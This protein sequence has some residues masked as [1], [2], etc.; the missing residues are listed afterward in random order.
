MQGLLSKLVRPLFILESKW[1]R[2]A[3]L[4]FTTQFPSLLFFFLLYMKL[5]LCIV[6]FLFLPHCMERVLDDPRGC[7]GERFQCR[8]LYILV[9]PRWVR[10]QGIQAPTI[11]F[12]GV[13]SVL[14]GQSQMQCNVCGK[15]LGS[16]VKMNKELR[17]Q[18]GLGNAEKC[19]S[20]LQ[21]WVSGVNHISLQEFTFSLLVFMCC[22]EPSHFLSTFTKFLLS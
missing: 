7:S 15:T 6:C 2:V 20:Y 17:A 9:C 12:A 22:L 11:T 18:K 14:G 16:T 1:P 13:N 8:F 10:G 21:M 4:S 5:G 19:R 3:S